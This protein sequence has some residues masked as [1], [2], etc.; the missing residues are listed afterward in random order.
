MTV[1]AKFETTPLEEIA[2]EVQR[3]KRAFATGKSKDLAWRKKQ[4]RAIGNMVKENCA[5]IVK[6]MQADLWN[7][8]KFEIELSEVAGV[9][10]ECV[11]ALN[12][13]DK[14]V[15]PQPQSKSI[16]HIGAGC[17]IEPQPKGVV[18]VISA[19]N[20]PVSL[21]L[22]PAVDALAAGNMVVLKP[23]EI[24]AHTA[25]L[26][27]QLL[28]KYLDRDAF[29]VV[30]GAVKETTE[31]L[32]SRFDHIIYTGNCQV[33]KIVMTRAAE[34]LTPV[35]LEMGGKCPV[36]ID[37]NVDL[38]T[39]ANR[40][41]WG[42]WMNAGQ[43]C[44]AP[45]YILCPPELQDKLVAELKKS[46]EK[47]YGSDA[48]KSEDY[49][50]IVS[51]RQF[52]RLKALLDKSG[53]PAVGGKTDSSK[54]YIEP[55]IFKDVSPSHPLMEEEIFGPILPIVPIRDVDEAVKFINAREKPLALYVFSKD[56]KM[57]EFVKNNTSS[58]GFMSNH[59]ILHAGVL[60]LPFGGTGNSGMGAYHGYTGFMEF[61]HKRAVLTKP[62]GLEFMNKD[63]YAPYT[64]ETLEKLKKLLFKE[65]PAE[66]TSMSSMLL[67]GS[68][69]VG[70]GAVLF[71]MLNGSSMRLR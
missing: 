53:Q 67:K 23:S 66:G 12:N 70:A 8:A 47:F 43:T 17:Y 36:V 62:H 2:P 33:G 25:A 29:T 63:L 14:W 40:L 35:T 5:A 41:T 65:M 64:E 24:T 28:P 9:I 31:L 59:T 26:M 19:W 58:G 27:T 7:K 3:V 46:L 6:A 34:H 30:N 56:K 39:T 52:N 68:V 18:L 61:S 50:H 1:I 45:D 11:E 69:L 21:L 10:S 55:T 51:D 38:E 57:V 32:G 49:C 16:M 71:H 20:Y 60:T 13:L 4:I 22:N 48:A 37:S 44:I 42:K 15:R 54:R